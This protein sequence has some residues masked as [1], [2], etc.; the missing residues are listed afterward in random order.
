MI[1]FALNVMHP[2]NRFLSTTSFDSK[3]T[4]PKNLL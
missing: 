1:I 3:N 4:S 2:L